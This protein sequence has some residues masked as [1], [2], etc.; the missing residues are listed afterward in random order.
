MNKKPLVVI[1]YGG[2]AMSDKELNHIFAEN[3][4]AVKSLGWN[5]LLGHGGGPQISS[6]LKIHN[7]ESKFKNGL[8]ITSE[9]GM[10]IVEM[11]LLG[12]V[13]PWLVGL[14]CE[15]DLKAVGLSGKDCK[16]LEARQNKDQELGFV[17][18]VINVNTE[19]CLELL[20][21]DYIP[22][23]APIGYGNK[24]QSLN[25]NADIATGALAGAL[26]SDIFLLI[27]DVPGVL[28]KNKN[29][30]SHLTKSDIDN[31]INDETIYGGMLPKVESCLNALEK[32]C[33]SAMIFD[34]QNTKDLANLLTVIKNGL[35]NN[36]FSALTSGT[37]ITS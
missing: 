32:G 2:H 18:E 7:I 25:I 16:T 29:R 21:N 31:L 28:D 3:I 11:A 24:G 27:T 37:V 23:V 33:K 35:A 22:I 9:E 30:Y 17:G 12:Q 19:L 8:R 13:N 20:N 5:I 34:G 4:K 14:I 10:Q 1:K 26:Q 15:Y 6:L 36:D